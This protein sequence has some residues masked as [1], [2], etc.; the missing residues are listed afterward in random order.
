VRAGRSPARTHTPSPLLWLAGKKREEKPLRDAVLWDFLEEVGLAFVHVLATIG[1]TLLLR[2]LAGCVGRVPRM[3][4]FPHWCQVYRFILERWDFPVISGV[5][6]SLPFLYSGLLTKPG[7]LERGGVRRE[8][9]MLYIVVRRSRTTIYNISSPFSSFHL[10]AIGLCPKSR[11]GLSDKTSF[12]VGD[13]TGK[14]GRAGCFWAPGFAR[15]PK[16][17][18]LLLLSSIGVL[19]DVDLSVNQV[20]DFYIRPGGVVDHGAH[21]VFV[22]RTGSTQSM[23]QH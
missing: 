3:L 20:Q 14:M 10:E 17:P 8:E 1:D 5:I 16:T 7:D 13:R 22:G 21:E 15:R 6:F 23:V 11:T 9:K 4:V 18:C 19:A 12:S 2:Q